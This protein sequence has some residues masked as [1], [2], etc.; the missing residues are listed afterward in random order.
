MIQTLPK[1]LIR[2][3]LR[4]LRRVLS[5]STSL[6]NTHSR[7]D[8]PYAAPSATDEPLQRLTRWRIVA[9]TILVIFGLIGVIGSPIPLLVAYQRPIDLGGGITLLRILG[10]IMQF[11]GAMSWIW[12]GSLCWKGRW[13]ASGIAMGTGL[14]LYFISSR[15]LADLNL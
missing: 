13:Q 10:S 14:L 6:M 1:I 4:W 5:G 3:D 8:N 15:L 11:A 7:D 2:I 9:V 12:S